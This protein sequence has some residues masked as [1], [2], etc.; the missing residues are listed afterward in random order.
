MLA[1]QSSQPSWRQHWIGL[2][3]GTVTINYRLAGYSKFTLTQEK[4][5]DVLCI[6]D[7]GTKKVHMMLK[8]QKS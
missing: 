1:S 5:K 2:L 7:A 6:D 3:A 4:S 8:S